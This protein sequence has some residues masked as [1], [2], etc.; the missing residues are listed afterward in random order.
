MSRFRE[1]KPVLPI[2]IGAGGMACVYEAIEESL[3]RK[4]AT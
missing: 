1:L 3:N 2:L 4:V